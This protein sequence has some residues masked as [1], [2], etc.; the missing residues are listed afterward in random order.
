MKQW[1]IGIDAIVYRLSFAQGAADLF[2]HL[3]DRVLRALV[4]P[5]LEFDGGHGTSEKETLQCF[6]A[7]PLEEME[8]FRL[9][10]TFGDRLIPERMGHVDDGLDDVLAFIVLADIGNQGL[11]DLDGVEGQLG[12]LGEVGKAGPEVVDGN[13]DTGFLQLDDALSGRSKVRHEHRLGDFKLQ[14]A[15]ID[16][17]LAK[18]GDDLGHQ[19]RIFELGR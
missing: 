18:Y 5:G 6:T 17:K 9:F 16:I 1:R 4:L 12:Q 7:N 10:D 3:R 2:V 13:L 14:Q 19:V 8:L 15:R 11:I